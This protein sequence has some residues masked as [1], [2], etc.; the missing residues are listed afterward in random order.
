MMRYYA[1]F[2]IFIIFNSPI[3]VGLNRPQGI[4]REKIAIALAE[5]KFRRLDTIIMEPSDY[6]G[7]QL[8]KIL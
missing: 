3:L 7:I 4:Y 2:T 1:H 6:D 5:F 8:C